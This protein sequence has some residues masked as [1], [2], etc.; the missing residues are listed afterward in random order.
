MDTVYG[1]QFRFHLFPWHGLL[2][3]CQCRTCNRQILGILPR[4][5]F[6]EILDQIQNTPRPLLVQRAKL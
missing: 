6:R 1:I 3:I 2:A 5:Q 4:L